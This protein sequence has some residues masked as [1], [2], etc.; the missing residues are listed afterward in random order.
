MLW[1]FYAEYQ[2]QL[3][4]KDDQIF[5]QDNMVY[6][7]GD[8]EIKEDGEH[9]LV[10]KEKDGVIYNDPLKIAVYTFIGVD[11]SFSDTPTSDYTV[12]MPVA[13]SD[14]WDIYILPYIRKRMLT[15]EL[16]D[17]IISQSHKY[18]PKRVTIETGAAQD[19]IRKLLL[20]LEDKYIPG[21]SLKNTPRDSKHR[22]YVDLLEDFHRRK[23][24]F[25]LREQSSRLKEEMLLHPT[26][27]NGV[28]D[29]IDALYW[30][31]ARAFNPEQTIKEEVDP[32]IFFLPR[33]QDKHLTYMSN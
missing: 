11:P 19:T 8:I 3:R 4:G 7:D 25:L 9:T 26:K 32:K 16:L 24:I 6:W 14:T 18:R 17:T 5:K 28:D 29:T 15:S 12:I 22:R 1:K 23:R 20:R 30:A 2:C 21:L 33:K 13:V 31:V 27:G 10:I